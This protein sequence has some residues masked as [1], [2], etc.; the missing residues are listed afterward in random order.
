[1]VHQDSTLVSKTPTRN[2]ENPTGH[3]GDAEYLQE[4]TNSEP[5]LHRGMST[6][7]LQT[8]LVILVQSQL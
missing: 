7:S 8:D 5:F 6:I 2:N 1:M 4:S 3:L